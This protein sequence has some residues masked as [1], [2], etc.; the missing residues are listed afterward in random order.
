[1][2][3]MGQNTYNKTYLFKIKCFSYCVLQFLIV[4][5]GT[6]LWYFKHNWSMEHLGGKILYGHCMDQQ[7]MTNFSIFLH[8]DDTSL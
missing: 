1:M 8:A 4:V 3:N 7:N 6:S 2:G 5:I